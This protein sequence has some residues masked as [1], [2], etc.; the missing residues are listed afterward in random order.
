MKK[1]FEALQVAKEG[2]RL[3]A[4]ASEEAV[5]GEAKAFGLSL[6]VQA[7]GARWVFSDR[8]KT[9]LIYWPESARAASMEGHSLKCLTPFAALSEAKRLRGKTRWLSE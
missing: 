4:L 1:V 9:L 3:T 7:E 6:D 8:T 2:R 5:R